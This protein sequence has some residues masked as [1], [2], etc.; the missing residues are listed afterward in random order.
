[1]TDSDILKELHEDFN[2]DQDARRETQKQGDEDIRY[3]TEGSYTAAE[4]AERSNAERPTV[5]EDKLAQP[6]NQVSNEFLVNLR[7][8]EVSPEEG[9][10]PKDAELMAGMI[11]HISY[12][13]DASDAYHCA[14]KNAVERSFG[15]WGILVEFDDAFNKKIVVR[16]FHNPNAVLWD[17]RAVKSDFSDMADAFVV[18]RISKEQRERDY[19]ASDNYQSF[20]L[21][22]GLCPPNWFGSRDSQ[23]V[24]YWKRR[25]IPRT[26]VGF[27]LPSGEIQTR[28]EDE[29]AP[30]AQLRRKEGAVY[31][32]EGPIP[33]A[34]DA[35]G[36]L[37]I[38]KVLKPEV[39]QYIS[40]GA[41]ILDRTPWDG[42]WI[43]I[44]PVTG[45]EFWT[46]DNKRIWHSLIRLARGSQKL[47]DYMATCVAEA[48]GMVPKPHYVAYDGV[49]ATYEKLWRDA[50]RS[51]QT[52]LPIKAVMSPDGQSLLP[53][54][55]YDQPVPQTANLE[56]GMEY[57]KAAIREAVGQYNVSVGDTEASGTS[58]VA[59]GKLQAQTQIGAIHY[60][61]S[62][63]RSLRHDGRCRAELLNIYYAAERGPRTVSLRDA[64][65][66]H[67]S[68]RVND[69]SDQNAVPFGAGKQG[70]IIGVGPASNTEM[71]RGEAFVEELA[72][73]SPEFFA[74]NADILVKMKRLPKDIEKELVERNTPPEFKEEDGKPPLPP[75]I[76]KQ[77]DDY[78][79]MAQQMMERIKE[80]T[81]EQESK[82]LELDTQRAIAVIKAET[83]KYIAE[84]DA[85][86]KLEKITSQE[87]VSLQEARLEAVIQHGSDEL[88]RKFQMMMASAA[89][90][91]DAQAAAVPA[92]AA[93]AAEG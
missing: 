93:P 27:Q 35:D 22:T 48:V 52:V 12:E 32:P 17:S 47:L 71:E 49:I 78:A 87:T 6:C 4:V 88:E 41:S 57:R 2:R 10:P 65:G 56:Q 86:V 19:G 50:N 83:D 3:L 25:Q 72:H 76:Q 20:E 70:V 37:L 51:P 90:H 43:P 34:R 82:A 33:I 24:E 40:D 38:R 5:M 85:R 54:P 61:A 91:S 89:A 58:G 81:A 68:A 39:T 21:A 77:L 9:S 64:R 11:R 18:S 14:V 55:R 92:P 59:I 23:I 69:P 74:K 1:M 63:E 29:F 42:S 67:S 28:Y 66:K 62:F 15:A 26:L 75:E 46:G 84:M 53:P 16:K 80:L 36:A 31:T 45:E 7:D 13:S 8:I 44:F 79:Q 60:R 30:G 73:Q